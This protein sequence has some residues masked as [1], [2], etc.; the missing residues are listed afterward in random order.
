MFSFSSIKRTER[1][2]PASLYMTMI[3]V[4]AM[5]SSISVSASPDSAPANGAKT[6]FNSLIEALKHPQ[7]AEELYVKDSSVTSLS[8]DI[9]K[10]VNLRV[11]VV[12][13]LGLKELPDAIGEL[14]N[15]EV[16]NASGNALTS[17]PKSI[18]KLTKLQ[19]LL[20]GG[21]ALAALP[22]EIGSLGEL[23]LLSL[24]TNKLTTLPA[25][26]GKLKKLRELRADNN[27]IRHLP[28]EFSEMTSLKIVYLG[29]FRNGTGNALKEV[30]ASL[31]K[32]TWLT[33]LYLDNNPLASLPK[34]VSA[35]KRLKFF[36][37][38]GTAIKTLPEELTQLSSEELLLF[39]VDES[40]KEQ[41][42]KVLP[43]VRICDRQGEE[44]SR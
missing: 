38:T 4:A 41:A 9:A 12:A 14:R 10:L 43:G 20:L 29:H 3:L 25:S 44:Y 18:G 8:P 37:I 19:N 34:E 7:T 30:P 13:D 28:D 23:D 1:R 21:N 31:V 5:L 35:L 39:C 24:S 42:R 36:T 11:L 26:I 17:I 6:E 32:M 40:L 2:L 22:D 27:Q 16:L 15:L 33:N